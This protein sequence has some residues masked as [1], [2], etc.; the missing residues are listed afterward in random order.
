MFFCIKVFM[1]SKCFKGTKTYKGNNIHPPP[2]PL[3]C[4]IITEKPHHVFSCAPTKASVSNKVSFWWKIE[5][6]RVQVF[7]CWVATKQN[8]RL[9]AGAEETTK[10][11]S[12]YYPD[13]GGKLEATNEI[14]AFKYDGQTVQFP[15]LRIGQTTWYSYTD[16]SHKPS[17]WKDQV[18]KEK[19]L[20]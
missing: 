7:F 19:G 3:K 1:E 10:K 17:H 8:K 4:W 12:H 15:M 18:P 5:I 11:R 16:K 13:T 14:Q 6:T 9:P 2:S 20:E